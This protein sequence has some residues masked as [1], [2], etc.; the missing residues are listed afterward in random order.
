M[1]SGTTTFVLS[2]EQQQVIDHRGGHL[3]VVA[4]AG[5]GKTES[6]SRRVASLI[7]EGESPES[8]IAFG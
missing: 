7:R 4:C 2:P 3:Q 6:I 5:S 8:I 1:S